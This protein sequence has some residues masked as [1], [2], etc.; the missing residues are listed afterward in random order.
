M[1]DNDRPMT[2]DSRERK[3]LGKCQRF[4]LHVG[5]P[6]IAAKA[7]QVGY[8][9]TEH[10]L[11]WRLLREASGMDRP[12]SHYLSAAELSVASSDSERIRN[13][14]HALD[15]FENVWFPRAR[16]AIRRF[17]DKEHR[18]AVELAFFDGLEQQPEG[19]AVVGSVEKL[20]ERVKALSSSDKAGAKD[21]FKA[22]QKKGFDDATVAHMQAL[23][24]DARAL[25]PAAPP[26]VPTAE[27]EEADQKQ[28]AA[29][30]QLKLWYLDWA[31][32]LRTELTY[33]EQLKLGLRKQRGGR[34]GSAEA[35]TDDE[36][37]VETPD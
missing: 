32:T 29:F 12:F 1:T 3:F 36:D 17:V 5:S 37:G 10:K 21:A 35:S 4:L 14:I 34:R 23:I 26:S 19:P 8:D 6:R 2:L 18:E 16:N 13:V 7:S 9:E 24:A 20:L 11:G 28:R 15:Q 27:Q 25:S 30:E 22:L 33:Q 31:D